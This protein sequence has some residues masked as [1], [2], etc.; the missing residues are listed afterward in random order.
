MAEDAHPRLLMASTHGDATDTEIGVG[1]VWSS[2]APALLVAQDQ[3]QPP[4]N[5]DA[6]AAT[7]HDAHPRL[8]MAPI[9]GDA[10]DTE[11][12]AGIVWNS[13]APVSLAPGQCQPPLG[14]LASAAVVTDDVHPRLSVAPI[15]GDEMD[16]EV[17]AGIV[18]SSPAPA[19]L[20]IKGQRRPTLDTA[21]PPKPL[22]P[23]LMLFGDEDEG[24][25]AGGRV[26]ARRIS[27]DGPVFAATESVDHS[28]R[29]DRRGSGPLPES[30]SHPLGGH[31]PDLDLD[32][33][34]N[35][36]GPEQDSAELLLHLQASLRGPPAAMRCVVRGGCS[37]FR[38]H[39]LPPSSCRSMH[40]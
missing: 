4:G 9:H 37:P 12:G 7:T 8:F 27:R 14:D 36:D 3:R 33:R 31:R 28:R 16:T 6:A 34:V 24:G 23:S 25:A 11:V 38:C 5:V 1:I 40:D 18:W 29:F 21:L 35:E 26:D 30:A 10:M 13:P 20:Q 19:S 32:A 22:M 39:P 15:H 17:G 2:P